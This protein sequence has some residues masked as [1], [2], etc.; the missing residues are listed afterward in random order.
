MAGNIVVTASTGLVIT[1]AEAKAQ[2]RVDSDMTDEDTLITSLIT[3]AQSKLEKRYGWALLRQ[4]RME[5]LDEFPSGTDPMTVQF[6]PVAA[7][8]SVEYL[9]E[10]GA[11]QTWTATE[12]QTTFASVPANTLL[13]FPEIRPAY[14]YDYPDIRETDINPV[15]IQ[16]T[17]GYDGAANVPEEIKHAVKLL[18][19]H[20]YEN[21]EEYLY[22]RVASAVDFAIEA[23]MAD[24]CD[25]R[26]MAA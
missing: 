2:M 4:T 12:Y 26:K 16:Y 15:R 10:D 11:E 5:L 25:P 8:S 20:W 23:L 22:G 17:C 14:G 3:A 7:I 6:P 18:V 9:D 21:R 13:V 24:F 1:L 19:S